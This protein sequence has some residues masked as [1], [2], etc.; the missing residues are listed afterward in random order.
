MPNEVAV[1][2]AKVWGLRDDFLYG[3]VL[4]NYL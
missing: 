3:A 2:R 4:D 1:R